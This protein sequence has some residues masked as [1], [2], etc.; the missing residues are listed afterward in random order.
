MFNNKKRGNKFEEDIANKLSKLGYWCTLL[1]GAKGSN[2]QPADIIA[3]KDNKAWLIDCKLLVK[4]SG[5][6]TLER[7]EENQI[8]AYKRFKKCGNENYFYAILWKNDVYLVP[9]YDILFAEK[10]SIN[11]KNYIALW[12]NFY[13]DNS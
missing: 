10:K 12:R 5:T 2:S 11:L 4:K 13:A 6:F 7:A 9:M 1:N 3:C 8:L